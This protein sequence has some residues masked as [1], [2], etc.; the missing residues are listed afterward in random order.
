MNN[1][2]GSLKLTKVEVK[3]YP[4]SYKQLLNVL[5]AGNDWLS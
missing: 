4:I 3:R 2:I 1:F 5:Q